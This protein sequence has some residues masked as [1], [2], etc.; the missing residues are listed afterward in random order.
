MIT[1]LT[2]V[3][4][5]QAIISRENIEAVKLVTNTT[6]YY[7]ETDKTFYVTKDFLS[8][9]TGLFANTNI[10]SVDFTKFDFSKI[11]T[12]RNWFNGCKY[13]E[14]V[15][16]SQRVKAYNLLDLSCCFQETNIIKLNMSNWIFGQYPVTLSMF[17]KDCWNLKS[18]KLPNIMLDDNICIFDNCTNLSS[19]TFKKL[20]FFE[21][22]NIGKGWF[23]GCKNL[24][25][26]DCSCWNDN[27][28][29]AIKK[30][31][32]RHLSEDCVVITK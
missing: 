7:N 6:N 20:E 24:K 27:L 12:M 31:Q 25:K 19:V 28:L 2:T 21:D 9:V 23:R 17:V 5:V 14:E 4:Q 32:F 13:L 18:V 30:T 1:E 26:I 15:K 22:D 3:L 16:F 10:K 11:T 29:K 8:A